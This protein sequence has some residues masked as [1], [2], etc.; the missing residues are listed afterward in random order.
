MTQTKYEIADATLRKWVLG[1]INDLQSFCA[2]DLLAE[3]L[4]VDK[5]RMHDHPNWTEEYARMLRVLKS[6]KEEHRIEE[7][8]SGYGFSIYRVVRP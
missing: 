4:Q 8:P 7:R 5:H 6:L 2:D 3:N 1:R